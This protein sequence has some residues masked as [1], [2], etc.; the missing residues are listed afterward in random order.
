MLFYTNNIFMLQQVRNF[1][2]YPY[3]GWKVLNEY[4]LSDFKPESQED[5]ELLQIS[6]GFIN[7]KDYIKAEGYNFSPNIYDIGKSKYWIFFA[8]DLT[9]KRKYYPIIRVVYNLKTRTYRTKII[10]TTFEHKYGTID[11]HA[12]SSKDMKA[13]GREK[14]E[15][16][17]KK[18][19][20]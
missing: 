2:K 3:W 11:G 16:E 6:E 7:R 17:L 18:I 9:K 19:F 13:D 4:R 12:I 15:A 8:R 5:L 10:T 14:I 20:C 1:S